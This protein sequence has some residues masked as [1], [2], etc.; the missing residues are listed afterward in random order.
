M[1]KKSIPSNYD[2]QVD[3]G[4]RIFLQY[5]QNLLIRKFALDADERW[6]YLTYLNTPCRISRAN[7]QI[8]E[9]L[10]NIWTECRD[11]STVMTIYDLLCYH[12]GPGVPPLRHEWCTAG[13][14]SSIGLKDTG[15][16]SEKYAAVFAGHLKELSAACVMLGGTIEKP[17]AGAD[18]TCRIPVT[19]FFPVLLQ[20]W[21]GEDDFIAPK[22]QLMWDKNAN[23][24][25]H[26][27]TTFFL[28]GDLFE[29]LKK[30]VEQQ[31]L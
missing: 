8:D 11:Y 1:V 10:K 24:F 20:F 15:V 30:I 25:L 3:V 27:E 26:F 7:G 18:I 19:S 6:I 17:L 2:L 4:R 12:K 28:Q 14:F 29:R 9:L 22:L 5:D 23:S 31:S 13:S 21:E 16:F